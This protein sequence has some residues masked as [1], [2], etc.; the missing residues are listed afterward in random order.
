MVLWTGYFA[1][2]PKY[3]KHGLFPV[4]ISRWS[5]KWLNCPNSL[6]LAPSVDL[7]RWYKSSVVKDFQRYVERYVE[8]TLLGL[9]LEEVVAD[10][11]QMSG[12]RD[13]VLCCYE[14]SD[15]FCHR[16]ILS[17]W[18]RQHGYDVCEFK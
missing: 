12:G 5:P 9:K 4:S 16:H 10:L 7:L 13:I 15:E 6:D 3:E 1:S 18:F 2:I 14:K 11:M 8:E 17:E